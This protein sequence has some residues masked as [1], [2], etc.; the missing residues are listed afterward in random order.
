MSKHPDRSTNRAARRVK[1]T[2]TPGMQYK[3]WVKSFAFIATLSL[4]LGG[5][6]AAIFAN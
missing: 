1:T 6:L 5:A 4:F 2:R 3:P